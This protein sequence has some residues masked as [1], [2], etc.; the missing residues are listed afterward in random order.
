MPPVQPTTRKTRQVSSSVATVMPEIGLDEDPISPV[1][2]DETVTN[3]K[4]K[5]DDQDRAEHVHVQRR[6]GKDGQHRAPRCPAATNFIDRSRSVR[7]D[8]TMS[9]RRPLEIRQPGPD[10]VPDDRQRPQRD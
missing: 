3:R 2:R 5:H 7:S 10:A 9:A 6:G 8:W 1:S 4:P